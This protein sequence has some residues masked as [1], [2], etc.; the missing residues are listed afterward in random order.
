MGEEDMSN[1]IVL[2]EGTFSEQDLNKLKQEQTVFKIVD[3]YSEQL[4]ELFRTLNP[5]GTQ[6]ERDVFINERP[7]GDVAGS[8]VYYPWSGI[9]LHTLGSEE[10]FSL[11]T[12]R[13][14]LLIT[15]EEQ[16][17][18]RRTVV[19]VAG[20]SVGAGMALSLVQSGAAAAIKLAD[21]DELDTT[22]LNRLRETLTSVGEQKAALAARHIYELDP[23]ADVRVFG[24]G[25]NDD[26]LHDFFNEPKLD[27]VIDEI[28][29]F[30]MKVKLRLKAKELG[31]P[32]L[33]F[34]SLGDNI[35]VDIERFDIT[36]DLPIFHGLLGDLADEIISNPD[37]TSE[38]EKRYAV[39]IVGKEFVPTRALATLEEMGRTLVGR[40]QL[41]STIAIDGGLAAYLVRK[42]VIDN[43]P[44]SGRYFIKFG[45]LFGLESE[46]LAQ[47]AERASIIERLLG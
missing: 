3:L 33:M 27:F 16:E 5:Q 12:N 24:Q 41:Y 8:W 1:P 2:Q 28:D 36:P 7:S 14:Q 26:N 34:S 23:Y 43:Q 37:I 40:P 9:L 6:A 17:Q 47:T 18:L 39:L 30:K 15:K 42:I 46:D 19:G 44:D 21:F 38:D 29:D 10:L 20:M 32:V 22:N 35:L 45:G 11:R 25:L 31:I 4:K 13:N